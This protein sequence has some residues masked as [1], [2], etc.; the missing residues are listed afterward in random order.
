M[1]SNKEGY[2]WYLSATFALLL[3]NTDRIHPFPQQKAT[4]ET[5]DVNFHNKKRS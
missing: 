5:T 3:P 1:T 4:P 2:L